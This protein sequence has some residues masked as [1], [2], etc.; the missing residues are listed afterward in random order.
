MI[1]FESV[2]STNHRQ[3]W[4][5]KDATEL[6]NE[7]R[8]DSIDMRVPENDAS[9]FNVVVDGKPVFMCS[10][11]GDPVWFEDLLTYFGIEIW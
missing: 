10:S 8:S 5:Y 2:S 7:W 9:I 6:E 3:K 4:K 1:T 11:I